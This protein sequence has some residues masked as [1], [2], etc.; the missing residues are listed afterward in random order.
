M[1]KIKK[2]LRKLIILYAIGYVWEVLKEK[3]W[4]RGKKKAKKEVEID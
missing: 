3:I 1:G 2:Y 4:K